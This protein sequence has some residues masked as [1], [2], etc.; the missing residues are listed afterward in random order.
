MTWLSKYTTALTDNCVSNEVIVK[1]ISA[2]Q[3]W[4]YLADITK[5]ETY[6]T[7]ISRITL[8]SSGPTLNEG[9]KFSIRPL[10][11]HLYLL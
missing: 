3:V 5:W 8:R 9:D 1:V 4:K 2:A 6:Y 10:H 11:P 7:D